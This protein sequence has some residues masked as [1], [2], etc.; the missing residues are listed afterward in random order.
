M[1]H[2]P[3]H[4]PRSLLVLRL[5]AGFKMLKATF[6]I[7]IGLGLLSFYEPD[8]LASLYRLADELPYRVEQHMLREV[9]SFLSGLSPSRIQLLATATFLYAT[10]FVVEG[11]GLWRGRYWAEWLTVIATSSLIPFEIFELSVHPS[12]NKVLVILANVAILGY[13]VW[14]VRREY[15]L[16]REHVLDG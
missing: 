11:I 10:L 16:R 13:L 12:W 5:I 8:F 14:R 4:L 7:A 6:V 1:S 2:P 9:I 15:L 3:H